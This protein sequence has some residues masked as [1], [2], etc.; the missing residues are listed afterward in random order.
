MIHQNTISQFFFGGILFIITYLS[1]SRREFHNYS[2]IYNLVCLKGVFLLVFVQSVIGL[3]QY[4]SVFQSNH[5]GYV[6]K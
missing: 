6:N 1:F 4:I 3:L 5:F 2:G